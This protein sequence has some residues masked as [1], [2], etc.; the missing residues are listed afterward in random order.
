MRRPTGRERA[1][2]PT[3]TPPAAGPSRPAAASRQPSPIDRQ[4]LRL[5][6]SGHRS[7]AFR[8]EQVDGLWKEKWAVDEEVECRVRWHD[9]ES[10]RVLPLAE[11]W[12]LA[13]SGVTIEDIASVR[14]PLLW[15][16]VSREL[17]F[18]TGPD[19]SQVPVVCFTRVRENTRG[20]AALLYSKEYP[21]ATGKT[22]G[23]RVAA[24]FEKTTIPGAAGRMRASR[25]RLSPT[26][27]R[28]ATAAALSGH[29]Q[30]DAAWGD[31]GLPPA[32]FKIVAFNPIT[33]ATR[34]LAASRAELDPKILRESKRRSRIF[35]AVLNEHEAD[36]FGGR[37]DADRTL[38]P[39]EDDHL[40]APSDTIDDAEL[41]LDFVD[42][43]AR[44][45]LTPRE[46][47]AFELFKNDLKQDEIAT[48]L[49]VRPGTVKSLLA[50]ARTK[51]AVEAARSLPEYRKTA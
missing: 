22:V 2:W 12:S 1:S 39:L 42:L 21:D 37:P 34:V 41:R 4:L 26:E 16:A 28:A 11:V 46:L 51:L 13:A 25:D 35:A 49:G 20:L 43:V 7:A 23:D 48:R 50:S 24:W 10:E 44:A 5:L 30:G 3:R 8:F 6:E 45:D 32:Q 33:G 36:A 31:G 40:A 15:D 17:R 38:V 29:L 14:T 9:E 47:E 27:R 19:G 18:A